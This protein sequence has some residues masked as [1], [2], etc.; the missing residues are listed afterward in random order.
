MPTIFDLT[1]KRGACDADFTTNSL[2]HEAARL[3]AQSGKP[4]TEA[5]KSLLATARPWAELGQH[6]GECACGSTLAFDHPT[7]ELP[8]LDEAAA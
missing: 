5:G 2:L 6:I 7:E 4:V 3:D 8:Q 1:G